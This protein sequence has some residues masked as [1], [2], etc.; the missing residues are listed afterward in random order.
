MAI[1]IG[2][3]AIDR[4]SSFSVKTIVSKV[5]AANATG[6]TTSVEIWAN[7]NLENCEVA[8]AEEV[9]GNTFTTRSNVAIGAVTA[10][11]KQTFS[12]LSLAVVTGD[13]I[14][15]NYTAGGVESEAAGAGSE[16]KTGDFIPCTNESG[17]TAS[18]HT[19]SLYGTGEE[20]A[21]GQQLFCLINMMGY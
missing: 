20:V 11:S 10:G 19:I 7:T 9:A 18:T 8:M 15:M 14:A 6:T 2:A 5:N 16:W 4:A 3:P 17:F 21:V 13:F 12:G 1:D